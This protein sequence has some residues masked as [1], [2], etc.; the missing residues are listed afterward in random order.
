M[1]YLYPCSLLHTRQITTLNYYKNLGY[2]N[3]L[4]MMAP[5]KH[6]THRKIYFNP[7]IRAKFETSPQK[8]ICRATNHWEVRVNKAVQR[9]VAPTHD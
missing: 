8:S 7:P 9:I 3:Y 6:Y 1:A 4:M 5:I 2:S